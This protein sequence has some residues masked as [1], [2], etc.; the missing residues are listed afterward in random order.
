MMVNPAPH[1]K[2]LT[3]PI[4]PDHLFIPPHSRYKISPRPKM[5]TH[6]IASTFS[7]NPRHM[8]RTLALDVSHDLR[9]CI[10]R[11]DRDH[12]VHVVGRQMPLLDPALLLRGQFF[13]HFAKMTP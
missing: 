8:D 10:F 11:R 4:F 7:I 2:F 5:L 13:E 3:V 9:N 1:T 6:E 12:H